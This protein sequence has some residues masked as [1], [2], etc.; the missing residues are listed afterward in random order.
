MWDAVHRKSNGSNVNDE[1]RSIGVRIGSKLSLLLK[2]KLVK[3]KIFVVYLGKIARS[4]K[5][6][7][8]ITAL[9]NIGK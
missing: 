2:Y 6:N 3:N 7:G 5:L 4:L 1:A 9:P 8:S